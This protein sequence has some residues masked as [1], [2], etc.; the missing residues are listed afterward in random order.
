MVDAPP[1][2]ATV[3]AGQGLAVLAPDGSVVDVL[4]G[5][6][7]A[8]M[9]RFTLAAGAVAVAVRHR[10]VSELWYV[11]SGRGQMWRCSGTTEEIVD[12]M[13]GTSL[14]IPVGT[15]FQFRATDDEALVAIGVTIPPWPGDGEAEATCGPWPPSVDAGPGLIG[16]PQPSSSQGPATAL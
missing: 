10:T 4:A 1:P 6:P 7:E 2:F 8:S 9:A 12:L 3:G 16:D 5:L 14:S 11:V 13:P 15:D